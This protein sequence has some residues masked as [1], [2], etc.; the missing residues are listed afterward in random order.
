MQIKRQE[1]ENE[2]DYVAA[3]YILRG[4][5]LNAVEGMNEKTPICWNQ[6]LKSL[7]AHRFDRKKK[8]ERKKDRK[9]ARPT[10]SG[11]CS[12]FIIVF[13]TRSDESMKGDII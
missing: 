4:F 6:I 1:V 3:H 5:E 10:A 12:W 11:V 9:Q 13:R 7:L 8:K 2:D